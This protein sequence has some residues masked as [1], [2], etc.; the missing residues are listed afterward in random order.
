MCCFALQ[1]HAVLKEKDLDQTLLVLKNELQT[2]HDA[3][4]EFRAKSKAQRIALKHMLENYTRESNQISLM[5]Y[6]QSQDYVFDLSYA[7]RQSAELSKRFRS[8][9]IP[10]DTITSTLNT[11][12][13]RYHGLVSVLNELVTDTLN[14][15]QIKTRNECVSLSR[16]IY[17]ELEA[18]QR[19]LARYKEQYEQVDRQLVNLG[20]YAHD[21]YHELQSNIFTQAGDNYLVILKSFGRRVVSAH[22]QLVGKYSAH[23]NEH[24]Q[25]RGSVIYMLFAIMFIYGLLATLIGFLIFRFLLPRFKK[26]QN[27]F[28]SQLNAVLCFATTTFAIVVGVISLTVNHNFIKMATSLLFQFALLMATIQLSMI[29]RLKGNQERLGLRL[30]AP[31]LLISF[32]VIVFRVIFLPGTIIALY[33][34]PILLLASIWQWVAICHVSRFM[35]KSDSFYAWITLLVMVAGVVLSTIGRTMLAVEAVTWWMVQLICIQ[36][37]TCLY[38][39]LDRYEASRIAEGATIRDTW[40]FDMI[41]R[42]LLPI[43]GVFSLLFSMYWAADVFDMAEWVIQAFLASILRVEGVIE[44]SLWRMCTIAALF[45]ICRYVMYLIRE[46]LKLHYSDGTHSNGQ[47]A[48]VIGNNFASIVVWGFFLIV[49]MLLLHIGNSWILVITGGLSTGIGFAMKDTLE[50]FFYGVSLM[51]GRLHIGDMIECDGV[52]GH[53]VNIS[54]QITTIAAIDGSE[55]AFLNS[56]LVS[57][58]FRN[59]TS[60]HDLEVVII[61]VGVAYGTNVQLVREKLTEAIGSLDCYDKERGVAVRFH[62]FGASSVDLKIILWVNVETKALSVSTIQEV[63]YNTLNEC[64]I[65]IPFPQLDVHQR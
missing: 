32:M 63:I 37:I 2:Y 1:T 22:E 6:S 17:F 36:A 20:K 23:Q 45:Y 28:D 27:E 15:E 43:A 19:E 52:R 35:V 61:P 14:A 4:E 50:N 44:L 41:N 30:Y 51:L 65:E 7:C 24:S 49:S 39:L 46:L 34:P 26:I 9:Q 11:E 54:Y 33:F 53:V 48:I 18:A 16:T 29:I 64:N 8:N 25:W 31:I 60:N 10:F 62:D 13:T 21:R 38:D 3:L 55:M 40:F 5:V 12:V 47:G 59:L 57:K 58:N 56:Q 42:M